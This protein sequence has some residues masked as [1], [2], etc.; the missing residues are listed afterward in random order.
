MSQKKTKT[1]CSTKEGW[2]RSISGAKIDIFN[3]RPEQLNIG[4]IAHALSMLCRF[5]GHCPKF[6]SVAQHSVIVS[7]IVKKGYELP[8]LLHDVSEFALGD[9]V[10]PLKHHLPDFKEIEENFEKTVR[11]AF[12]IRNDKKTKLEV[13]KADQIALITEVRDLITLDDYLF[14]YDRNLKPHSEK[15]KPLS[16]NKAYQLF[17][18]RFFELTGLTEKNRLVPLSVSAI[19]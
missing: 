19:D 13:K 4:D 14:T 11:K 15:I 1:L 2:I 10:S 12:G 6:Y 17:L 9:V 8:A 16:P 3:P 7:N 18:D 5:N